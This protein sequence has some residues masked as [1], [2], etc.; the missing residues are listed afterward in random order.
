MLKE[1]SI[2]NLAIVEA[3]DLSFD[4]GMS[5][6]TGE[7]GAGKSILIDA[8]SL[9][10]GARA[11]ASLVRP[12]SSSAF[13]SAYFEIESHSLAFDWL[14]EKAL[15]ADEAQIKKA[16]VKFECIVRRVITNDGRSKA[17]INGH[18]ATIAE[19]RELGEWLVNIHGQ[20]QN[21]ALLKTDYQRSLI[22]HYAQNE[23]LCEKVASAYRTLEKLKKMKIE[24]S[25]LQGQN[26]KLT[27][28]EYQIQELDDLGLKEGEIQ[29]LEQEH[30]KLSHAEQWL[31]NCEQALSYLKP[32]NNSLERNGQEGNG[33]EA[34]LNQ[35]IHILHSLKQQFPELKV[36]HELLN[37]ALIQVE[38]ASS[39]LQSFKESINIDPEQLRSMDERLSR[40][41]ATA[42]KHKIKIEGIIEH[43]NILFEEVEKIKSAEI[44][45]KEIDDKIFKA[46]GEY[47]KIAEQLS[48]RRAQAIQ[49]LNPLVTKSLHQLEMKN[50]LFEVQLN[51]KV[52]SNS[53]HAGQFDAA[54][55]TYVSNSPNH[56]NHFSL[57]GIDEIEFMVTT[58]PGHPLQPLR[59]VASGGEM[60]RVSLAIQVI[61]AQKI[62][63]PT[64]IFD[65]VD[66]GISGKTA[67]VVGNLLRTLGSH[68]QVL[69]VT[70]LPQVA[71]KA[72]HHFKVE[73]KQ[74]KNSTA[75]QIVLLDKKERIQEVARMLGG[76]TITQNTLAHAE[77]MLEI[78]TT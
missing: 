68:A 34:H 23:D 32:D 4:V 26:D 21:Q 10:L 60:S 45:L 28:L 62:T 43:R 59:K 71:A 72:H 70:H 27:L 65:E 9:C 49:Q 3:L 50:G 39:E 12:G 22:D 35:T 1:L 42:R 18:P 17:F 47:L 36:C 69:C 61:T 16:N 56:D 29:L 66:V 78:V 40:I 37:N 77:E 8:L 73:K 31:M 15:L 20:H 38:E 7:T 52:T 57:H 2:Q 5:G 14:N 53:D 41:H 55:S 48:S 24:L 76:I 13:I 51:R 46:E 67:E 6:L 58:N 64:L 44:A 54:K 30:M 74:T 75:T 33:I 11:E 25:G 19:L 63:T